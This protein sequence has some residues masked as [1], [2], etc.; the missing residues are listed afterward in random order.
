MINDSCKSQR[1]GAGRFLSRRP[2]GGVG[3]FLR[4][5]KHMMVS[6]TEPDQHGNPM[7]KKSYARP[8]LK[9]L[10][11]QVVLAKLN[12]A[13]QAGSEDAQRMISYIK[14]KTLRPRRGSPTD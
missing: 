10:D 5:G 3:L 4:G 8:T 6:Q 7:R 13:A 14:T 9:Q 1:F 12:V 2:K 11:E